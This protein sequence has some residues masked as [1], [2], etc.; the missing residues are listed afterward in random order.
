MTVIISFVTQNRAILNSEAKS[1]R[2]SLYSEPNFRN[3]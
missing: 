1:T 3:S 2:L